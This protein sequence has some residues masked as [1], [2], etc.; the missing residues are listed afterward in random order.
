VIERAH[1]IVLLAAALPLILAGGAGADPARGADDRPPRLVP[2]PGPPPGPRIDRVRHDARGPVSAGEAITVTIE[3]AP[4]A[5]VTA[6]LGPGGAPSPCPDVPDQPGLYRCALEAPD[7][8]TGRLHVVAEAASGDA[9][10]VSRLS[11]LLPVEI[12]ARDPLAEMN[13]LNVRIQPVYFAA[14]SRAIDEAARAVIAADAAVIST[15]PLLTILVEGHCDA[16]EGGDP[17]AL[18]RSRAEAVVTELAAMGIPRSRMRA[19]ARG[20]DQPVAFTDDEES[21]ALNRRAMILLEAPAAP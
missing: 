9:P 14:G 16:A 6:R 11:S 18:S 21:R 2:L 17:A 1:R 15:R 5:R 3:G 8:V 7:G 10:G 4:G 19:S 20:C 13:A 12:V